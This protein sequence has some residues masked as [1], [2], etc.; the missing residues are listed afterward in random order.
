MRGPWRNSDLGRVRWQVTAGSGKPRSNF[1]SRMGPGLPTGLIGVD[2]H[3]LKAPTRVRVARSHSDEAY[4]ITLC[5]RLV[6]L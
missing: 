1:T 2:A 5:D 4:V 6:Q 3:L